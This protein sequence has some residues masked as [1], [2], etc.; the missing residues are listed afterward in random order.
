MKSPEQNDKYPEFKANQITEGVARKQLDAFF[1]SYR[2][3]HIFS[4]ALQ[5]TDAI[6]VGL[7][8]DCESAVPPE[9]IINLV[10]GFF[11][12]L[13]AGATVTDILRVL[14][15]KER[16]YGKP[17]LA[18]RL[19][20]C[21]VRCEITISGHSNYLTPSFLGWM[22]TSPDAIVI[23]LSYHSFQRI[24]LCLSTIWDLRSFVPPEIPT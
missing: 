10:V 15:R 8:N 20:F 13:T 23:Y 11:T 2:S 21:D 24:F 3:W 18:L 6:V 14:R 16:G 5:Y 4:A 22:K 9:Q 1:L 12:G 17:Q 19:C 7:N